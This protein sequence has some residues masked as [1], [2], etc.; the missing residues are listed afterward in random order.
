MLAQAVE[1]ALQQDPLSMSFRQGGVVLD[2]QTV[3]A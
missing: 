3:V 2:E 1:A